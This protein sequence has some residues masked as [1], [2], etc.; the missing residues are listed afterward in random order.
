MATASTWRCDGCGRVTTLGPAAL[1]PVRIAIKRD[2]GHTARFSHF[3]IHGV[4]ASCAES[5]LPRH[6]HATRTR[7]HC[8]VTPGA[9]TAAWP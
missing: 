4:C 1:D 5:G 8:A 3:A 9:A 7:T 2:F 6:G